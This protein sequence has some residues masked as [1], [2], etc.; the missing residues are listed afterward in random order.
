MSLGRRY[1]DKAG[2]LLFRNITMQR[3]K[4]NAVHCSKLPAL[5][6]C[7]DSVW[8]FIGLNAEH[9]RHKWSRHNT[10][11]DP[12]EAPLPQGYKTTFEEVWEASV[13]MTGNCFLFSYAMGYR[14]KCEVSYN[15]CVPMLK[16][17]YTLIAIFLFTSL[18]QCLLAWTRYRHYF[19]WPYNY[20]SVHK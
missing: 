9:L 1:L 19:L 20:F 16:S 18:Q 14:Q 2:T 7:S 13:L 5:E 10:Q 12:L 17:M 3:Y 8:Y 15:L 6:T 4:G 11:T